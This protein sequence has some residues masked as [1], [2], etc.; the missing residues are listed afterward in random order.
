MPKK[1]TAA[2]SKTMMQE[3]FAL[4]RLQG[5]VSLRPQELELIEL[6]RQT[7]YHGRDMVRETAIAMQRLHPWRD[8][9]PNGNTEAFYPADARL[10]KNKSSCC[11]DRNN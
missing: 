9:L 4:A 10:F 11:D 3:V 5:W 6:L 1:K 2:P 8:T 7:T